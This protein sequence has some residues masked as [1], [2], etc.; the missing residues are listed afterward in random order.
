LSMQVWHPQIRVRER[1]RERER[2]RV[3]G[4]ARFPNQTPSKSYS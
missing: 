2:E 1:E 4:L 3:D